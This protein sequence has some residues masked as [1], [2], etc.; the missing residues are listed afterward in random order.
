MRS[1]N[2]YVAAVEARRSGK[3]KDRMKFDYHQN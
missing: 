3:R 1:E 2:I